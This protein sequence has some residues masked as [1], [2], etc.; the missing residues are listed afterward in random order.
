MRLHR[1][2]RTT[3]AFLALALPLLIGFVLVERQWYT[4]RQ[5]TEPLWGANF[6]CKRAEYLGQNCDVALASVLDDLGVRRLCLSVYWSD[7]EQ[8]PGQYDFS[9]IDRQLAALSARDAKAFVTIGMKAQRY[10]EYWLPTWLR[11]EAKIP[12]NAFPEDNPLIQ[13]YLF[14][15]LTA[16]AA[17]LA[18]QPAVEALQVDNEPF[19]P[20]RGQANGWRIRQDFLLREIA[21]IRAGA[22]PLPLA[23]SH[24]SWLRSDD[25]WR[26]IVDQVD[27]LA[28]A[29]YT[30]R[31]RGPWPWLYIFPY[32]FGPFTPNLPGQAAEARRRSK[33]LWIG[34]LQAEPFEERT[35][36]PR[37]RATNGLGSFS[38]RW[39]ADNVRL[40]RR[41]QATRAYLWGVEWW[42]Y[43]KE[44]RDEP[45]LWEAGRTLFRGPSGAGET[46][47]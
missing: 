35:I 5:E 30:K 33:Q 36:D 40:A 2:R 47:R 9:A 37:R 12:P 43:L 31:Q 13:Q 11:L 23:I 26:W 25:T 39:L 29:V 17:H 20:S 10:P 34:E 14:P 46:R 15:F 18:A 24:A 38:P 27:V 16:A 42:L 4:T 32:R 22:P 21:A 7:V 28:Q 41:S 44:Q 3:V 45:A 6:S 8:T 19:V 1:P